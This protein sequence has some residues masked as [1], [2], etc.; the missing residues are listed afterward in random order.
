[1]SQIIE[2][3]FNNLSPNQKRQFLMLR[4]LYGEWNERINV[5]SRKDIDN[6]YEHH[7]L[8]SL[9]IGKF[10]QPVDGT[11]FIDIGTGGGFPGIPLAIL[12][13]SCSFH[14]IDRIRKKITVVEA[15][16]DELGLENVTVQ[17]GD[18]GE[19]KEKFDYAVSRAAMSL[20][21]LVKISR[22]NLS[23]KNKGNIYPSGTVALKGGDLTEELKEIHVKYFEEPLS[24]WFSEPFFATKELIYVPLK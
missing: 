15:V 11:S 20:P 16:A 22:K 4:N 24:V 1:M 2:K 13:P 8:H 5:I 17:A 9:A 21:L 12:Y 14:L 7:V 18:M 6:L 19:C 23:G 10:L 3:Y